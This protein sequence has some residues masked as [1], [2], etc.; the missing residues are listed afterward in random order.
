[1]DEFSQTPANAPI[2]EL[3]DAGLHSL[4]RPGSIL[5]RTARGAGWV[6]GWRMV[7]R[8]LGML[9]TLVLVRL[10][11]PADFGIVALVMTIAQGLDQI[12]AIG[13]EQAI[14]RADKPSRRLYDT[15]F[16]INVIRGLM[17]ASL[18]AIIAVPVA[19]FFGDHR[20]VKII[21]V[22]AFGS[23]I[24]AFENIGIVDFRRFIAFDKE[25]QL[26]VFPRVASIIVAIVLAATLHSYWALI[27][28][29]LTS[30]AL[31]IGLGYWLHPFRPRFCLV[32]WREISGYSFWSWLISVLGVLR[33]SSDNLIIGH[34]FGPAKVGIYG[35]GGEIAALPS[36]ELVAP[37]CRAAFGGF[38]VARR[39]G[40]NGAETFLRLLGLMAV[41]TVPMGL[42]LSLVADPVIRL[43]FGAAWLG[44]APLVHL[45]GVAGIL[46][47]FGSVSATL[48]AA[49]AWLKTMM[50]VNISIAALRVTLLIVLVPRFGIMGA[51][52]AAAITDIGDQLIYLTMTLRKLDIAF[53][54]VISRV[55]R[56]L[57]AAAAMAFVLVVLG[58][59]WH[60]LP[61]KPLALGEQL[62]EA[63]V[64]GASVY[65]A[66]LIGLWVAVGRPEGV[67][68]DAF[69]FLLRI[70]KRGHTQARQTQ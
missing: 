46:T 56:T 70:S 17:M 22:A 35:V 55:I 51:A 58:L 31:T 67:E 1:M 65:I 27:G 42:G 21:Y 11:T 3:D 34:F 48:F 41:L 20:L 60:D 14:I 30:Q 38:A 61:G 15:G 23:A 49:N 45:L 37:L 33:S 53:S 64:L 47:I 68:T 44:A 9:S 39:Q 18:L 2:P 43:A 62:A 19:H 54:T 13:V 32:E 40:D 59:G 10:L 7:T 63:I 25:F 29:I 69:A 52:M 12:S 6:I 5:E 50:L 4:A 16:T 57:L 24:G 8:G 28:A 66:V 26:N 36:T